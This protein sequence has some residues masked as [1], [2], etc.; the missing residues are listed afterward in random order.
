MHIYWGHF[1]LSS[2]RFAGTAGESTVGWYALD[3]VGVGSEYSVAGEACQSAV[4]RLPALKA[5]CAR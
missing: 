5:Y 4:S 2:S 3:G 1:D